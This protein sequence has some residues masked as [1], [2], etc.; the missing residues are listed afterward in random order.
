MYVA[1]HL[2]ST[3]DASTATLTRYKSKFCAM[4]YA[5]S[6]R[7]SKNDA[8]PVGGSQLWQENEELL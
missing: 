4:M 2:R 7:I 5:G 8:T 6:D 3:A 1:M